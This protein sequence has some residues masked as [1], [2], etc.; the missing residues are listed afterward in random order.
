M[1]CG[2]DVKRDVYFAYK[3]W[4]GIGSRGQVVRWVDRS[5]DNFRLTQG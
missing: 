3:I 4:E 1:I 5:S 2:S